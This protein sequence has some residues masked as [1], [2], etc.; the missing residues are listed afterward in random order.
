MKLVEINRKI[1]NSTTREEFEYWRAR[2]EEFYS[3]GAEFVNETIEEDKK[4][5]ILTEKE[6]FRSDM[7]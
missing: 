2:R 5:G 4:M 1:A 3:T 7:E 6:E